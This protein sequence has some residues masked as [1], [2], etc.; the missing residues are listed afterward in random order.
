MLD[1]LLQRSV[2]GLPKDQDI[3]YVIAYPEGFNSDSGTLAYYP[4]LKGAKL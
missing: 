1:S 4:R 3:A 2:P